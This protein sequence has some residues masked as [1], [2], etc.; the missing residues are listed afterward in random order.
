MM[1]LMTTAAILAALAPGMSLANT[2]SVSAPFNITADGT[3]LGDFGA[4]VPLFNASLGTLT[5]ERL[6]VSGSF[7]PGFEWEAGFLPNDGGYYPKSALVTLTGHVGISG[8]PPVTTLASENVLARRT[9]TGESSPIYNYTAI[10]TREPFKVIVT[11]TAWIEPDILAW[12]QVAIVSYPP[13]WSGVSDLLHIRGT[14]RAIYTYT[15]VG[16]AASAS[17]PPT[18]VP[19]PGG[20]ALLA[21][22]LLGLG[23]GARR[24]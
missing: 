2:L 20:L 13:S 4:G 5:S 24:R 19:E 3:Y 23:I 10:G 9:T 17:D 21:S 12:T 18:G 14:A 8:Y 6:V 7:R 22:G 1:R 16:A 11:D 15:P